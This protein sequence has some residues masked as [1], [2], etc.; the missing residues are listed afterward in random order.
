MHGALHDRVGV[1]RAIAGRLEPFRLAV[2]RA[3]D[4]GARIELRLAGFRIALQQQLAL[5]MPRTIGR[6]GVLRW[7]DWNRSRS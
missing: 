1:E 2:R 7:E 6:D 4:V 3:D 5:R